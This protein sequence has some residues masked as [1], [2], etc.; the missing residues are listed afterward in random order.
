V[1]ELRGLRKAF[2]GTQALAGAALTVRRGEIHA[3]LGENGAGKSTL[4]KIL[5]GVH[6]ADAGEITV[7][8]RPLDPATAPI[9]FLHQD[10]G[11]VGDMTVAENIA[12]VAGY[13]RRGGLITWAAVR[14]RARAALDA[15][16]AALSPDAVVGSLSAAERSL[17]AIARAVCVDAE[18]LVLDE[19]T[20]AL[21]AGDVERLFEVLRRLRSRGMGLVYVTHRLDEVGAIA[22]RVTVLRNGS[23]VYTGRVAATPTDELV[24]HILGRP[25]AELFVEPSPPQREV[26]LDVVDLVVDGVGPVSLRVQ[27]GEV[28]GLVGRIGSGHEQ[29]G[30]A[31]FGAAVPHGGSITVAGAPKGT[32]IRASMRAGVGFISGR[33]VDEGLA[34][35]MSVRENLFLDPVQH[36][37]PWWRLTGRAGERAAAQAV[38]DRYDIRPG[39]AEQ[40]VGNLSGGN[41]QKVVVARW[42]ESPAR[43][44]VVEEPT[45]GVDVGAKAQI[46]RLLDQAVGGGKAVVLVSSDFAE[47]AATSFRALVF[48]RGRVVAELRSPNVSEDRL[49]RLASGKSRQAARGPVQE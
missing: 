31:I 40:A 32:G 16:G 38:V 11:L 26:L 12:L 24:R 25:L 34:L 19:P 18:L 48:D 29:T 6:T 41:Q 43:V 14:R 3:L 45:A 2:A 33:R 28:V 10:L 46:Y 27:A 5:A 30:R 36:G 9:A 42:L 17:V 47:V 39:D 8:G 20:A 15:V 37:R 4:I 49:N 13:S 7:D 1:L 23:T 21:A 35:G 22:D 44:L